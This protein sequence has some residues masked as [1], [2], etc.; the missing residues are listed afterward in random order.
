MLSRRPLD[1]YRVAI[2]RYGIARY[3]AEIVWPVFTE[4]CYRCRQVRPNPKHS[5]YALGFEARWRNGRVTEARQ[6][7]R[8]YRSHR[9]LS[10]SQ[11]REDDILF[12]HSVIVISYTGDEMGPER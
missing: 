6:I 10:I 1:T 8:P 2:T 4:R 12:E 11:D 9:T 7:G 5:Y 3:A